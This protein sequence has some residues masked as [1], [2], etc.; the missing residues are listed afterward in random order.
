MTSKE[1]SS[2]EPD[3]E[4]VAVAAGDTKCC[5][6]PST[7]A[8]FKFAATGCV[9]AVFT[10]QGRRKYQEDR[11]VVDDAAAFFAV[12]DGHCGD[13]AS[14]FCRQ[15]LGAK[16]MEH[17]AKGGQKVGRKDKAVKK[18]MKRA[19]IETDVE[20]LTSHKTSDGST[21]CVACV[22][23]HV[24]G[25]V[26]LH[27]AN[28][29]D[30]R[31]VLVHAD[32]T[33][34]AMSRDH[35]PDDFKETKR[36]EAA[37]LYVTSENEWCGYGWKQVPR[38]YHGLALSRGIGDK[39]YKALHGQTRPRHCAV[40]C[41]PDVSHWQLDPSVGNFL[42]IASDGIW[43]VI[44]N[45]GAGVIVSTVLGHHSDPHSKAALE[46]AARE[47]VEIAL[48]RNSHDNCTAVVVAL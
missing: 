36:I 7:P 10:S 47:L 45:E 9:G 28:A 43:D 32:G 35:K 13:K 19:F 25:S 11:A 30:S 18:A 40:T 46:S 44:S 38:V 31:C 26:R 14:E 15:H 20:F 16:V 48:C 41:V 37:G 1:E 12:Y 22:M 5:Q 2:K 21:A 23:R 24:D 29:G 8:G 33:V 34:V 27:V 4:A 3:S 6:H 42:V 39:M 17:L